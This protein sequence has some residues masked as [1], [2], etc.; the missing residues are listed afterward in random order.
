MGRA[1]AVLGALN[2]LGREGR[3]DLAGEVSIL[4]SR[5]PQ[6]K[7]K[8]LR[9]I[10]KVVSR[11]RYT[12]HM[13]VKVQSIPKDKL[14]FAV[15]SDASYGNV[16]DG[17]SQGGH[18][19]VAFD[20]CTHDGAAA[21]CNVLYWKSGRI[22]RVVNS[23]L[24][25]E[26]MSLSRGLGDL[27]WSV[28]VFN[29]MMRAHFDLKEWELELKQRRLCALPGF[30][31][32]AKNLCVVDA[33][34]LYDHLCQ[35]TCG[36]TADRRTAIEMQVIRQTL[37]EVGARVRWVDHN[38]MLV[39]CLT[40]VGGNVEPLF[41]VLESGRWS[42]VAED[43]EIIARKALKASGGTIRRNKG[44]GIKESFGSCESGERSHFEMN[45]D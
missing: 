33:K 16:R 40:K 22:H 26:S 9:E 45:Q 43:D 39:D 19:I 44:A 21:T 5:I 15:V 14:A 31:S 28:T 32:E 23:T 24:A 10:N 2:W 42:I 11:A 25:A 3:P 20:Q 34:S 30:N 4:S 27:A 38:R 17:G 13:S 41:H 6:L 29:E 7:V 18:C 12:S 8:D 1:R 37:T 36:H 35:E